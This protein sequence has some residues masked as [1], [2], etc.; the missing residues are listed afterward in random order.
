MRKIVG[1]LVTLMWLGCAQAAERAGAH[2][3]AA[4]IAMAEAYLEAYSS[5]DIGKLEKYYDEQAVFF[6]PTSTSVQGIGGPFRWQG[7]AEILKN[8]RNW[9]K[10]TRSL[11]YVVER[12]FE[13]SNYV[14][15]V[16]DVYPLVISGK[17]DVQYKYP[18][19][20]I[21]T[22]TNGRVMEHRDYTNYAAGAIVSGA[23][24]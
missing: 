3:D 17:G 8:I 18:I 20:T 5:L 21:V 16:G 23:R 12:R 1:I 14:V 24:P 9:S 4:V 7:R 19:I 15:F 2:G 6:D 11:K 22:I 10:S 13:S